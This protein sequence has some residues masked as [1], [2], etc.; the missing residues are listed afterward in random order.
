M[1]SNARAILTNQIDQAIGGCP[2][3][4]ERLLWDK[5]ALKKQD[6]IIDKVI[7]QYRADI[8]DRCFEIIQVLGGSLKMK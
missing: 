5:D 4:S 6:A 7:A 1:V 3:G 8:I 2:V